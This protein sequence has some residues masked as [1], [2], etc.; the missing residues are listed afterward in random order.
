MLILFF[1][2]G[3]VSADLCMEELQES[4]VWLCLNIYEAYANAELVFKEIFWNLFYERLKLFFILTLWMF[5]PLK[6]KLVVILFSIFA[7]IWGFFFMSS[8]AELGIA[9]LVIA[10][11]AVL[12]PGMVYA[13]VLALILQKR[14]KWYYQY[15]KM[16][17]N[18]GMYIFLFVLFLTGCAVESLVAV[19]F[20]PWVIR[21]SLI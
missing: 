14:Q 20:V 9:G 10:L 17:M 5:T 6:D 2:C 4:N 7:F 1:I 3:F 18:V 15:D 11:T 8:I 21:L 12:P 13:I 16:M 19:H